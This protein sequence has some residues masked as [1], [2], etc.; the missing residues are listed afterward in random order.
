MKFRAAR[1]LVSLC[2]LLVASGAHA[3]VKAWVDSSEVAAD[4]SIQLTLEHAGQIDSEPDLAPL[5]QDFD[6]L[7]SARSSSIQI[8]NGSVAANV[9]IQIT[10]S[11]K[12]GGSI[13][14]PSLTWGGEHTDP[15]SVKFGG[16][17]APAAATG[18]KESVFIETS[19]DAKQPYVQAAVNMTVKIYT[20]VPLRHAVLD[21]PSSND[22]VVQQ[23]GSDRHDFE[24]K[25]GQ[26]YQVVERH[27]E[28]FPQHSGELSLPA[29]VLDG[30][31]PVRDRG[32]PF[33]D[34]FKG[35][36]GD[37]ILNGMLTSLK[38]IRVHGDALALNVLPRP[39]DAGDIW[40]PAQSVTF[41]ADW[42]PSDP[43]AK[44]GDPVAWHLHLEA[45]GLMAAQLPDLNA[46]LKLPPGVK[47][48]PD[49]PRLDNDTHGDTVVG[50]RDQTIALI[51]DQPGQY[52][53]PAL[54]LRWW[55]TANRQMHEVSVPGRTLSVSAAPA[56]AGSAGTSPAAS[57]P[58]TA[59]PPP[60]EA[61]P[62]SRGAA[63]GATPG[64]AASTTGSAWRWASAIFA[65]LWLS[66]MAA[67]YFIGRRGGRVPA[68]KPAQGE[69]E[70]LPLVEARRAFHEA[71]RRDDARA[72]RT[73]LIRW[74]GVA[75]LGTPSGGL[76][77]LRKHADARLSAL[78]IEL[79]RACFGGASWSGAPLLEA[80]PELPKPPAR[81]RE[82]SAALASLYS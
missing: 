38:P 61:I 8:I 24:V 68:A 81:K 10:L 7:S 19:V 75:E 64:A 25:D 59:A 49:Q 54:T 47:A 78:L 17:N 55:D 41:R 12:H 73:N 15:I 80:L 56:L 32:D 46:L 13:T 77:P 34:R 43:A 69:L 21:L 42:Q 26:R 28:V 2:A 39:A 1:A 65:L 29:P 22:V 20:A 71:C 40:L 11:P 51:A 5:R 57:L 74:S 6:V 3:A 62:A 53:I 36:F 60:G 48:Y 52:A 76:T 67:W 4:G 14:I 37:S 82:R 79:D 23:V 27:Y 63:A 66:T 45:G 16:Q 18:S 30:Q 35:M 33:T 9:Q 50:T 72:A 31:I 70:A 44:V 58:A